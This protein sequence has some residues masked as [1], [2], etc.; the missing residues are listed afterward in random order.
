MSEDIKRWGS[1][2]D[3]NMYGRIILKWN[4]MSIR[5]DVDWIQQAQN[6]VQ[7]WAP[8]DAAKTYYDQV[9]RKDLMDFVVILHTLFHFSLLLAS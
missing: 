9:L 5:C 4:L 6:R 3:R 1:L 8:S 7:S 2:E